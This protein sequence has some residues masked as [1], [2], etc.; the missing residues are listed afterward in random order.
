MK[1]ITNKEEADFYF[2]KVNELIDE[3]VSK[4]KV[5]P[6]ELFHYV[7]RNLESFLQESGFN[8]VDGIKTVV[9]NVLEHRLNME[10]DKIMKFENFS[11]LQ[12]NVLIVDKST[13]EHEK[14]LADHYNTSIG[15]IDSISDELHLFLINDFGQK[16]YAIIFSDDELNKIKENILVSIISETKEKIFS[17]NEIDGKE[18]GFSFRFWLGD[19][20]D[21]EKL[22]SSI[23]EKLTKESIIKFINSMIVSSDEIPV[24][25]DTNLITYSGEFSGYNIWQIK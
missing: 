3:Y 17:I 1:R 21:D 18:F 11:L 20:V 6:K 9:N 10:K 22:K 5:R 4:Y 25:I 19:I 24:K 16:K 7:S 13:V 14:V 23:E 15:H 8:D 12:E 2:Q